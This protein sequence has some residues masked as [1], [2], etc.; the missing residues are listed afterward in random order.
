MDR[1]TVSFDRERV[2]DVIRSRGD[3]GAPWSVIA[4]EI[5]GRDRGSITLPEVRGVRN[6]VRALEGQGLVRKRGR[7]WPDYLVFVAT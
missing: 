5:L 1:P 3:R 7:Y 4:A 6:D 2:L